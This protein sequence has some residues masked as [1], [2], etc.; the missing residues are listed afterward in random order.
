MSHV[1]PCPAH[2]G[3]N[4]VHPLYTLYNPIEPQMTLFYGAPPPPSR[5]Q[6]RRQ[7]QDRELD[8]HHPCTT[9]NPQNPRQGTPN[10]GK[11]ESLQ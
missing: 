1:K 6:K 11:Q 2:S 7:F 5:H 3:L 10:F 9:L 4:C 8:T